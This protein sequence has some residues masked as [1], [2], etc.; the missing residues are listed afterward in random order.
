MLRMKGQA[1]MLRHRIDHYRRL[2][3]EG[4]ELEMAREY[5]RQIGAD[6]AEVAQTKGAPIGGNARSSVTSNASRDE[7][8]LGASAPRSPDVRS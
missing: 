3:R 2:L 6:Q 4:A 5:L 8:R 7:I 1:D